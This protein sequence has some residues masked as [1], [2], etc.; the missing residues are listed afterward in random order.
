M[1]TRWDTFPAKAPLQSNLYCVC[2]LD[3]HDI[4]CDGVYD[5]RGAFPELQS[6]STRNIFP[7]LNDLKSIPFWEGDLRE[8]CIA[9]VLELLILLGWLALSHKSTDCSFILVKFQWHARSL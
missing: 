5:P 7:G 1:T 8:V 3:Y 6:P 4:L 9:F 2:S